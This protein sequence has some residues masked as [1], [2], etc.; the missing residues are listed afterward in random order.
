LLANELIQLSGEAL[1]PSWKIGG[2]I[3]VETTGLDPACEEIIEL[4]LLLFAYDPMN[5]RICGILDEYVGLREPE[6]PISPNAAA[7]HGLTEEIVR[8]K[9]LDLERV[10]GMAARAELLVAHNA[11]F[12]RSFVERLIPEVSTKTWLCSMSGVGWRRKGF[13]SRRLQ[14][15]L[16]VHGI[17]VE[18]AHRAEDDVRAAVRLLTCG[19]H[20]GVSYFQELLLG[21]LRRH[22]SALP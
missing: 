4:A 22:R 1:D 21:T 18:R 7:V 20:E 9:R 16:K 8:G 17:T 6:V 19:A 5:G 11:Q 12:D 10:R 15:L 2:Y 3:D 13:V 14:D